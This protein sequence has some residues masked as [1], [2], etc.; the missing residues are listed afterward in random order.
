M[1]IRGVFVATVG[2]VLVIGAGSIAGAAQPE[3]AS[4]SGINKAGRYQGKVGTFARIIMKTSK[5]RVKKLDAGVSALC[6]RASDGHLR[7]PELVAMRASANLKI[8][9]KRQVL[10]KRAD[11]GWRFLEGKRPICE[12]EE[13]EGQI[14]SQPL[15]HGLQP[16]C[17][18]R[19]GTLLRQRKVDRQAE[20]LSGDGASRSRTGDLLGAIQAL[21]QLSYSPAAAK[22]T[23]SRRARGGGH[24]MRSDENRIVFTASDQL[25]RHYGNPRRSNPRT[26]GPET[27]ARGG[28]IRG[29]KPRGR[30]LRS[31]RP[32]G[33]GRGRGR[34]FFGV[35]GG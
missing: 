28:R 26:P 14:R 21:C 6:Q 16:L 18:L 23:D 13:G 11:Q 2:A 32:P 24:A 29:R 35:L 34:P 4:V 20:G 9:K 10:R 17:T 19:R 27:P 22:D 3:P 1:S 30:G 8:K 7:G 12:Q 25:L 31:C 5:N 15:P 33:R